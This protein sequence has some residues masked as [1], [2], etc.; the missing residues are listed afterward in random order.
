MQVKVRKIGNAMG[1]ILPKAVIAEAELHA[2][3]ALDIHID[4]NGVSLT[5]QIGDLKDRILNG[6]IASDQE[7]LEFSESFSDTESE[8][9]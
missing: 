5:K 3:D 4:S 6:I 1:V 2:G 7:N 8:S 9:W